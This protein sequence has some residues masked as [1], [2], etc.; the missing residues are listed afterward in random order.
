[1]ATAKKKAKI[2]VS[3]IAAGSRTLE[4]VLLDLAERS[5]RAEERAARAEERSAHAE[6]RSARAEEQATLAL[7]I[8]AAV[9]KDLRAMTQ[10][11]REE[12]ARSAARLT[13]LEQARA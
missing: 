12:N 6:E 4:G 3:E 9:T 2:Q 10:E 8:I 13:V 5:A 1:M 7:Q 11:M